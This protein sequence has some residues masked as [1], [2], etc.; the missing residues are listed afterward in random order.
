M[1]SIRK[2]TELGLGL[3]LF[4]LACN[5]PTTAPLANAG[6]ATAVRGGEIHLASFADIKSLD[7]AVA[8]DTLTGEMIELLFAGLVDFDDNGHV[9]PDLAERFERSDDGL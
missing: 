1:R 2:K 4:L 3:A 5:E 8:A 9:V 7:P 6:N